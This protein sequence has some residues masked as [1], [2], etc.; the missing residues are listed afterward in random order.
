MPAVQA[1]YQNVSQLRFSE[2]ALEA[3]CSDFA[4]LQIEA[5]ADLEN[6]RARTH[7]L[8]LERALELRDVSYHYPKATRPALHHVSLT[9]PVFSTVAIVGST[10]SGKTT[11]VDL[12][13]GLL[14]PSEGLILADGVEITDQ[15]VRLWQRSVGYVPQH[16]FLA[17][18]TIA[19]NIAFGLAPRHIDLAAVERA[20]TIANLHEFVVSELPDGYQTKVGERG[21][22][23]SGGQRQR[24][25]IA[26]ALYHDPDVLVLD[27]ATSALD[28]LTEQAVMEAVHRL[29]NRKTII[30]IAHRLTT[31]RRCDCIHLLEQGQ[32]VASG[33]FQDLM[34]R[35]DR[36][37]AMAEAV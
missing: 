17:D 27:E 33:T 29:S 22:R 14:R 9:I 35:S 6:E 24:I 32:L 20:A 18:E 10:G 11:L 8:P 30:I 3:L 31:V 1:V 34:A 25:G 4:S 12:V 26:R 19:G 23:L 16:I 5:P 36:F 28:N 13:L 37:R 7:R 15:R 2:A 21:V